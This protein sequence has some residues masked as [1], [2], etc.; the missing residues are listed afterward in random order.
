MMWYQ[1]SYLQLRSYYQNMAVLKEHYEEVDSLLSGSLP[2]T[3]VKSFSRNAIHSRE[4]SRKTYTQLVS[5]LEDEMADPSGGEQVEAEWLRH[6]SAWRVNRSRANGGGTHIGTPDSGAQAKPAD[7]E[8]GEGT[9]LL[10]GHEKEERRDRIA[11]I[12]LYGR[13]HSTLHILRRDL[14]LMNSQYRRQHCPGHRKSV[15]GP[16]L[17]IDIPYSLTGRF[18]LRPAQHFH[19]PWDELGYRLED[20]QTY[21]EL[22]RG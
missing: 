8:I 3:V 5:D 20:G 21:S 22:D 4:S 12:A 14:G 6:D 17:C 13:S 15:R 18:R 16:L 7:E 11:Q 1:S 2:Y 19:H 9:A 10:S